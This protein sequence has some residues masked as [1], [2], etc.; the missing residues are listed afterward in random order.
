MWPVVTVARMAVSSRNTAMNTPS[1]TLEM[2]GG[3]NHQLFFFIFVR[4]YLLTSQPQCGI[5]VVG[6]ERAADGG[7]GPIFRSVPP[8]AKF[9][10]LLATF[11]MRPIFP[12]NAGARSVRLICL[13]V[14]RKADRSTT[15]RRELS[16]FNRPTDL[17]TYLKCSH[18]SSRV[19]TFTPI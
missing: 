6:V 14:P 15:F 13:L 7:Q 10:R 17:E 8:Y 4:F 5:I 9:L 2:I 16:R 3:E 12:E 11:H 19:F 1:P 18:I